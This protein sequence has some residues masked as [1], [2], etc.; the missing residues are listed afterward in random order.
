MESARQAH[1]SAVR[2][3]AFDSDLISPALIDPLLL[4]DASMERLTVE[5]DRIFVD[6]AFH[7][8]DDA[9]EKITHF[10]GPARLIFSPDPSLRCSGTEPAEPDPE[11]EIVWSELRTASETD[12][13]ELVLVC[14]SGRHWIVR[15]QSIRFAILTIPC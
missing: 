13:A 8:P 3:A 15:A 4:R 11:D 10:G 7:F 1:M 12:E 14:A 5:P 9:D 6:L 2:A